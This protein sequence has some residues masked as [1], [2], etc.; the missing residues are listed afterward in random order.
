MKQIIWIGVLVAPWLM[1]V[2]LPIWLFPGFADSNTGIVDPIHL[3]GF[4]FVLVPLDPYDGQPIRYNAEHGY[5]WTPGPDGAFDGKVDFA[6]DGYPMWKNR[7]YKFVQLLDTTKM[8]RPPQTY[9]NLS[10]RKTPK[11][12]K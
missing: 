12:T 3:L 1:A 7:N 6:K 10:C 4:E 5:F 11:R 2:A 9:C 8:N